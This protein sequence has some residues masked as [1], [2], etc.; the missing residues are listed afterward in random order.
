MPNNKNRKRSSGNPVSGGNTSTESP[1]STH[2]DTKKSTPVWIF[3]LSDTDADW[4]GCDGTQKHVRNILAI[5]GKYETMTWSDIEGKRNHSIPVGSLTK[6]AQKRLQELN[7]DDISYLFSLHVN[8]LQ[9]LWGIKENEEF[10]VL[11]WDPKHE[12]YKC[13]D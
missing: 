4:S 1:R 12:V 10:R 3:L 6:I 2:N 13:K 11:W 9:R 5:L 7:L 8:G